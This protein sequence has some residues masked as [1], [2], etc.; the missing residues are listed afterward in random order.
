MPTYEFYC[1]KCKKEFSVVMSISDYEKRKFK[2]PKCKKKKDLK[3]Q[4][5]VFTA[6]TSK[7]S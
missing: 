3:Q 1:G 5:T 2:C 4:I 7:K 6:Q